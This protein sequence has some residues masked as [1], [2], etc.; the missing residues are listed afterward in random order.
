MRTKGD[1]TGN[2]IQIHVHIKLHP[3]GHLLTRP[4]LILCDV[5]TSNVILYKV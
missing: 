5:Y 2:N 4:I 3:Y 1:K